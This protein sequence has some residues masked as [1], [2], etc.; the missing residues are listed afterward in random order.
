MKT[1]K[2]IRRNNRCVRWI[3]CWSMVLSFL[4]LN[5][6]KKKSATEPDKNDSAIGI[7]VLGDMH[8]DRLDDHDVNWLK[9]TKPEDYNQVL[10]YSNYTT[11]N[12]PA[13]RNEWYMQTM[14]SVPPIGVIVQSG[15]LMEGLAGSESLAIQMARHTVEALN[16]PLFTPPWI[17]AKGNH[18][19]TGPGA[20]KA[21]E[22]V[23]LPFMQHETGQAVSKAY[24]GYR[25]GPVQIVVADDYDSAGFIPFIEEAL[26]NSDATY[27]FVVVHQP[28]IPVTARCW[29]KPQDENDRNRLLNI[30][31][32]YQA[33]VL[34]GHL[35]AYS[36]ARRTTDSGPVV[37]VMTN[38]VIRDKN[39]TVPYWNE[40]AYGPSL[41][42]REPGFSPET[43]AERKAIL[44]NET[45]YIT[46]FYLADMPGYSILQVDEET[47]TISLKA[48]CGV[49]MNLF[50]TTNLSQLLGWKKSS[51]E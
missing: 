44:T 3:L 51:I 12:Y 30:L 20:E 39:R 25:K 45:R 18:E 34:C 6:C 47:G 42:G 11:E 33:I 48:Y 41:M 29:H 26:K 14:V 4:V 49:G 15:D 50:Q 37:Q 19:M 8:Y 28:V 35:H 17:V 1:T 32:R 9:T 31:A 40:T 38:S 5:S 22:T 46:H 2:I 27:Q 24:F 13:S 36:V 21:Y 7:L 16:A 23:V 10:N 43:E